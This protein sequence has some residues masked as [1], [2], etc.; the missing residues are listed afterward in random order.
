M[1]S[2]CNE[3][4]PHP[5]CSTI[6]SSNNKVFFGLCTHESFRRLWSGSL[7]SI[8]G[9]SLAECAFKTP[10][11][12]SKSFEGTS[13][14]WITILNTPLMK[15]RSLSG[16]NNSCSPDK[17]IG[18]WACWALYHTL[19]SCQLGW[20]LGVTF[21]ILNSARKHQYHGRLEGALLKKKD[22]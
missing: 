18:V 10:L 20:F 13:D 21:W 8:P 1:A 5:F 3:L 15:W 2:V 6:N 9:T 7:E 12:K 14:Q 11:A 19:Q 16:Q 22:C 17:S 4:A